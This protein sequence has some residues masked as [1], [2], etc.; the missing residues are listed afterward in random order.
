LFGGEG[1]EPGRPGFRL[2]CRVVVEGKMHTPLY[3]ATAGGRKADGGGV[4]C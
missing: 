4:G 2:V 1:A 3:H